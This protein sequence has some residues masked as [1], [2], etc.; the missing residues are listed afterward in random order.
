MTDHLSRSR[1]SAEGTEASAAYDDRGVVVMDSALRRRFLK[2]L[3]F[4]FAKIELREMG[5]KLMDPTPSGPQQWPTERA[6]WWSV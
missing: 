2:S 4:D 1:T 6:W 3:D 5:V